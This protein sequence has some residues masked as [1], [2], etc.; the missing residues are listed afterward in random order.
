MP[1]QARSCLSSQTLGGMTE[2]EHFDLERFM[3]WLFMAAPWIFIAFAL[4]GLSLPFLP[5]DGK[6]RNATFEM[7]FSL[8]MVIFFGALAWV[9]LRVVRELPNA[10]VSVDGHGIWRTVHLRETSLI[11]WSAITRVR[12]RP[13][14]QRLELFNGSGDLLLKLEYQLRDF[15]R[16]RT[17]VLE[18]SALAPVRSPLG[19][20]FAKGHA[21]HIFNAT[22]LVG[23]VA[24]SIYLWPTNPVLGS[25]LRLSVVGFGTWEYFTTACKVELLSAGMVVSWPLRRLTLSRADITSIEMSDLVVNSA[26]HP[27]VLVSPTRAFSGSTNSRIRHRATR[28][29]GPPSS[30][31]SR[32]MLFTR[33]LPR[34]SFQN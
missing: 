7:Y 22:A 16:L 30:A 10:P 1:R 25:V 21:Y 19:Q 9:S 20:A 5:D 3:R 34:N 27:Q 32:T 2:T 17:L 28:D 14:L 15:P 18:R 31:T 29:S 4:L 13:Y 8:V 24:L 23:F 26:L 12:E 6:P 33:V 11:H